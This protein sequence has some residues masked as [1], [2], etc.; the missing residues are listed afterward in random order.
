MPAIGFLNSGSPD[1]YLDRVEAFHQG[2]SEEI[3]TNAPGN[4]NGGV[5]V[6]RHDSSRAVGVPSKRSLRMVCSDEVR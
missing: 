3:Q 6:L 1:Q 5:E 4:G 2:L